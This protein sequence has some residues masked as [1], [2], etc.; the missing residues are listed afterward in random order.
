[1]TKFD[2]A[3]PA[4]DW[5]MYTVVQQDLIAPRHRADPVGDDGFLMIPKCGT[6]TIKEWT[7]GL[8]PRW[9][10]NKRICTEVTPSRIHVFIRDPW[11]RYIAACQELR[12]KNGFGPKWLPWDEQRVV[13]EAHTMPQS[14]FIMPVVARLGAA[15]Q[16][17]PLHRLTDVLTRVTGQ[18][19]LHRNVRSALKR[20]EGDAL[21]ADAPA[22]WMELWREVHVADTLLWRH[23]V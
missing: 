21:F 4:Y 11:E 8:R 6:G 17:H 15:V 13:Y 10:A 19:R 9:I 18:V 7:S 14:G 22:Q 20:A 1:M 2:L 16:I 23:V 5:N 3:A 12:I